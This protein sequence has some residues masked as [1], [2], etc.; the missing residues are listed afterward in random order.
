LAV[1]L[2]AGAVLIHNLIFLTV[3]PGR[4]DH[5]AG[6]VFASITV[7]GGACMGL[8]SIGFGLRGCWLAVAVRHTPALP[9]AGV[10]LSGGGLLLWLVLG[11][12]MILILSQRR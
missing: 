9:L 10:M 6:K 5:S 1:M 3:G 4:I 2:G 8:T 7:F 11:I 12:D